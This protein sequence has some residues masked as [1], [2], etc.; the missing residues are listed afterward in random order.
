MLTIQRVL[1]APPADWVEPD[2]YYRVE[3]VG[4]YDSSV[5]ATRNSITLGRHT[6]V[7]TDTYFG[8][9]RASYWQRWTSIKQ[10]EIRARVVGS[11]RVLAYTED[12]GGHL[13]WRTPGQRAA[14]MPTATGP[15][16]TRRCRVLPMKRFA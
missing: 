10:V 1:F 8:R 12:I 7:R 5:Q 3:G 14:R 15:V 4:A 16:S 9:F 6:V 2:L 13:T 11:A